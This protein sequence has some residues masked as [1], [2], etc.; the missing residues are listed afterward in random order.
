MV[1]TK[2]NPKQR[3]AE[4]K[5]LLHD[6][7]HSY[8]VLN[9]SIVPDAEYDRLFS[10][11]QQLEAKHPELITVDSPTQRVGSKASTS[12]HQIAHLVPMLSLDNAF[13]EE[14]VLNFEERIRERLQLADQEIIEYVCEPKIDGVAVNLIY[15]EGVLTTAATRGDGVIGENILPNV[16]TILRVPLRLYGKSFPSL[17]EVRGEVYLSLENF[18]KFNLAANKLGQKTLVNPRN[19][20]AGSLRQL[21]PKIT[22][23]RSL[24]IF[25]Y[26]IGAIKDGNLPKKH[27]EVL[28]KLKELGLRVN[29]EIK[30]VRGIRGCLDYSR[31]IGAKRKQLSYEIDGTVYKVNDLT[32]Q[33][34]LG[35]VARAPRWAIAYKFPAA[36]ELT[37]V[38]NIEFQVGRTGVLTPVARL[39]PVFVGG[40]TVSNATLHNLDEVWRKDVRVGDTVII[41][42]AGDVIPEIVA[43]VKERRPQLTLVVQLPKHCP[44]CG[45]EVVRSASGVAARCGGYLFCPAQLKESVRHFASRGALNI[46]G[47]G[48]GLV[49]KLVDAGLV[50]SVADLFYLTKETVVALERQGELSV[51]NFFGAIAKSKDTTFAKFIYAVGIREVGEVTAR[52]LAS[53]FAD[54]DALMQVDLNELETLPEI[55]PIVAARIVA[56]FHENRNRILINRLIQAGI[57]WPKTQS[58]AVKKLDEQLFVLTGSLA[59]MGREEAKERLSRLGAKVSET[60]S[61]HTSYL[62]VGSDPGSKLDQAKKLGIKLMDEKEFLK[63]L[64]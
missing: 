34:Q 45:A 4:L 54:L 9:R 22:A 35:F 26:T 50:K 51:Q 2:K 1:L 5:K 25:C 56:F 55:G 28:A 27:S 15:E 39:E 31:L 29:P 10:E 43:V 23:R 32:W 49:D 36:E 7:S 17:L 6:Y 62:I 3:A 61:K 21:D 46:Q 40:V 63:L 53:H 52:N 13:D 47:L 12:F 38:L 44:V 20:A 60:V 18:K 48:R 37:K 16:K 24:E 14:E 30:V 59:S 42:R 41:R 58:V 19:A 11:L 33:E 64:A 57:K 8:Y